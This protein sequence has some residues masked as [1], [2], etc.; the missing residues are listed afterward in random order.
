MHMFMSTNSPSPAVQIP[1][2]I[3]GDSASQFIGLFVLAII[4]LAFDIRARDV[5]D[6]ISGI[7]DAK[8]I[9]NLELVV[10]RLG[11]IITLLVIPI[12]VFI[13]L[14][15]LHGAVAGLAGWSFGAPIEIWSVLSFLTWDVVPILAWWGG[16]VMLLAV[17]LRNRLLVVLAALGI[18]VLNM[19][20][21]T[22]LSWGQMEVAGGSVSQVIHPSDVAPVFWTGTIALQRIAWSLMAIGFFVTAATLLPRMLPRRLLF[23]LAGVGSFGA[24]VL[25]FIGLFASVDSDTNQQQHWVEV[26]QMQDTTSFPDVE[27]LRGEI[28]IRPGNRIE[29]A[30][31][32]AV[33]PPSSNT[34]EQVI[35]TLNPGYK[36][37]ELALDGSTINDKDFTFEDGLLTIPS[38]YFGTESVTLS[39]DAVGKP[40]KRFAYLD[41]S[42]DLKQVEIMNFQMAMARFL[43]N[44]NYVFQHGYVALLPGINWY[45]TAGVAIGHDDLQ[46]YPRD[47]FTIDL[48]VTV[49]KNWYVAGPGKAEPESNGTARTSYRFQSTNHITDFAIIGSKFDRVATTVEGIE[50]ELLYSPKHRKTFKAMEPILPSLREWIAERLTIADKFGLKY[51]YETLTFVEVPSHL[52]VLGGGWSMDTT[53]YSPGIVMIRENLLPT[54]R[55]DSKFKDREGEQSFQELVAYVDMDL[56]GG[57]P[58]IGIA[59]NFAT[60]QMSPTGRGAIALNFFIEDLITDL[61]T[62]R[63][64]YFT[65]NTALSLSQGTQ[66]DMSGDDEGVTVSIGV[67]GPSAQNQRRNRGTTSIRHRNIHNLSVWSSIEE[68]AVSDLNFYDEPL[69]SY[70]AVLLRNTYTLATLKEFVDEVALGNMLRDLLQKF[71]GQNYSYEEFREIAIAHEPRFDEITQNFITSN[72][73]P[74]YI[75]SEP[76]IELAPSEDTATPVY[77]TVFDLRNTESGPGVVTVHWH[78]EQ[79]FGSDEDDASRNS[80]APLLIEPNSSYRFAIKSSLK[81]TKLFVEAPISLNREPIQLT[82][83]SIDDTEIITVS[84]RP[85]STKTQWNPIPSDQVIVDDL[86]LGFSVDGEPKEIELPWFVPRFLVE[87][88]MSQFEEHESVDRGL[89]TYSDWRTETQWTRAQGSGFGRYRKTYTRVPSVSKDATEEVVFTAEFATKLPNSGTWELDYSVPSRILTEE[90][91]R[92]QVDSASESNDSVSTS[93]N[94]VPVG[95]TV[96]INDQ[97]IPIEMDLFELKSEVDDKFGDIRINRENISD[98]LM[99]SLVHSIEQHQESSDTSFWLKL[100]TFNIVDPHVI[101]R[102][103]N[104]NSLSHTFADAVRW[105]YVGDGDSD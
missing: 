81:P 69:T 40:D 11:G 89:P 95:L 97:I 9:S 34:T 25:V 63:L 15:L 74:G 61:L 46:N 4:F 3:V 88:G 19:W 84:S 64:P 31:E 78:E 71:R 50:F 35:F 104:Q 72:K 42:I 38:R 45:P 103:S 68:T 67:G 12:L 8:P 93:S 99:S 6:R 105:T 57:N 44:Q 10:G 100:G 24:G 55:F 2:F 83:P 70:D 98:R 47:H 5:Q 37:T 22:T 85:T 7:I 65:T 51:P 16:L 29:L 14:V 90:L 20:F 39:I 13:F 43:G 23:G 17:V 96:Q 30:L 75:V 77:Q 73:L 28:N 91:I 18:F 59:R 82:I 41:A 76:T 62:E 21:V 86:D 27:H 26:H 94:T 52:R 60:Y 33:T 101:V 54:A 1:R 66:I 58:L 92:V 102:I 36:I 49:P 32:L 56:R 87:M 80:L 53:L 79:A 48:T